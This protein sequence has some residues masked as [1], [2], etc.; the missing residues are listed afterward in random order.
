MKK[1][2]PG[3]CDLAKVTQIVSQDLRP[4]HSSLHSS[5]SAGSVRGG[6]KV[7]GGVRKALSSTIKMNFKAP[8]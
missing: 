8:E 3:V 2:R 4:A 7:C 5:D 6:G 1:L